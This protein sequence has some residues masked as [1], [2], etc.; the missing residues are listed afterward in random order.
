MNKLNIKNKLVDISIWIGTGIITLGGS[1]LLPSGKVYAFTRLKAGFETLTNSYLMPLSTAVAGTA[2]V[3][4]VI[5][6]YFKPE[7]WLPRVGT[8]FALAIVVKGGLE[9]IQVITQSFS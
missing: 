9:I 6:S 8:V 5:M 2:L 7:V 4:C 1:T 3:A